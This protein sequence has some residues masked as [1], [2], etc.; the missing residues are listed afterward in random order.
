MGCYWD[1]QRL[2]CRCRVP[3]PHIVCSRHPWPARVQVASKCDACAAAFNAVAEAYA[4]ETGESCN[5]VQQQVSVRRV[6]PSAAAVPHCCRE[7][8]S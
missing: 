1:H 8:V 7:S 6:C 4:G 5:F 2:C 3:R